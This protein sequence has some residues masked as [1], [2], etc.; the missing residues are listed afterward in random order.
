MFLLLQRH[1]KNLHSFIF[2]ADFW[3]M[4]LLPTISTPTGGLPI[5]TATFTTSLGL[6]PI[7][8]ANLS[9]HSPQWQW[10][11]AAKAV[12]DWAPHPIHFFRCITN[13]SHSFSRSALKRWHILRGCPSVQAGTVLGAAGVAA[14]SGAGFAAVAGCFRSLCQ[15]GSHNLSRNGISL[16]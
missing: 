15:Q 16:L 9:S 1:Y 2:L 10:R 8:Y 5:S 3:V 13:L 14:Y 6:P 4:I 11:R 12:F 7:G